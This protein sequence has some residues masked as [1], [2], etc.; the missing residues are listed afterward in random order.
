MEKLRERKGVPH[1]R[2]AAA[3]AEPWRGVAW[4]GMRVVSCRVLSRSR[5]GTSVVN[6]EREENET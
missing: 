5:R 4:R 2:A 1:A 6:K 3:V